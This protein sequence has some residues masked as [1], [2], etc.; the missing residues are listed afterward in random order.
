[1]RSSGGERSRGSPGGAP[2]EHPAVAGRG[3]ASARAG[4]STKPTANQRAAS[5]GAHERKGEI[6]L[7][8]E[9][10]RSLRYRDEVS[11]R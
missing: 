10:L 11:F 3:S 6:L 1:M 7:L 2:T 5:F 4:W 9:A 8:P